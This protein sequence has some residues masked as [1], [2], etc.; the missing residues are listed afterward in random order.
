[1]ER[2]TWQDALRWAVFLRC[3]ETPA[4]PWIRDAD[5]IEAIAIARYG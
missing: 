5:Q 4:K 1:M 2:I 3:K